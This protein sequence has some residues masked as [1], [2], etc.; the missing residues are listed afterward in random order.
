[1]GTDWIVGAML[2]VGGALAGGFLVRI[3]GA[4]SGREKLLQKELEKVRKEF[5]D[6]RGEVESHFRETAEAVNAM[7][8]SYRQVYNKLRGGASRLCGD[9]GR[10]LDLKPAPLLAAQGQDAVPSPA[11]PR[12]RAAEPQPAPVS[13]DSVA[14]PSAEAAAVASEEAAGTTDAPPPTADAQDETEGAPSIEPPR[15]PLDYAVDGDEEEREKT[16]H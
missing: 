11:E 14:A 5:G 12:E 4:D 10:L 8:E 1:M 13:D 2:L 7:S 6:Y 3:F 16:L 9:G 15:A